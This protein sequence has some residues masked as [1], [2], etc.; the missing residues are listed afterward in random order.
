MFVVGCVQLHLHVMGAECAGGRDVMF[1]LT[2]L[3]KKGLC[4]KP[5]LNVTPPLFAKE[6]RVE[7]HISTICF[8]N[9]IIT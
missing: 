9:T 4:I 1:I 8:G 7:Y 3:I 5:A 6:E 2:G